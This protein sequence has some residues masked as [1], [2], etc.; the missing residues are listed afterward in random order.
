MIEGLRQNVVKR[1]FIAEFYNGNGNL[2]RRIY[3]AESLAAAEVLAKADA[4]RE[5]LAIHDVR[6]NTKTRKDD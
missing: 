5:N 4:K 1:E 3:L 2:D 6:E